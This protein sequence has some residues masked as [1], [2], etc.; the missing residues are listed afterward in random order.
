MRVAV[1]NRFPFHQTYAA[2][3]CSALADAGHDVRYLSAVPAGPGAF[4]KI[5]TV[6]PPWRGPVPPVRSWLLDQ[7]DRTYW[8]LDQAD[9]VVDLHAAT[10]LWLLPRGRNVRVVH[11]TDFF[12]GEPVRTRVR[13]A[14]LRRLARRGDRFVV[15]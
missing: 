14:R 2:R 6:R 10:T 1:L 12:S 13:R 3:I 15:H 7:R 11:R 9:L 8:N 5:R 4:Q